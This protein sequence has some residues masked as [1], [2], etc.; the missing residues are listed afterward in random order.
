MIKFLTWRD[1]ARCRYG[2]GKGARLWIGPLTIGAIIDR[3][4]LFS[5]RYGY[6]WVLRIGR[7]SFDARWLSKSERGA[8][9]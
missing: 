8:T 6:R 1:S 2:M 9:D 7:L 3:P 5:E 4:V